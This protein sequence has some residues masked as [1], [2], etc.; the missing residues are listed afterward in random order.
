MKKLIIL[1]LI[2][3]LI[4][5]SLFSCK[6]TDGGTAKTETDTSA[7]TEAEVWAVGKEVSCTAHHRDY[8][9]IPY[10]LVLAVGPEKS[11]EWA[12]KVR[13]NETTVEVGSEGEYKC[14]CPEFNIKA[15]IDEFDI[16]KED[17]V[18][19]ADMVYLG[20]Y[21]TNVLYD[22]TPEE[23]AEYYIYSEELIDLTIKSQHFLFIEKYFQYE[24]SSEMYDLI[25]YD[26]EAGRGLSPS[27]PQTVQALGISKEGFESILEDCT[28]EN[29]RVYGRSF[30]FDYDI[31]LIFNEDGS[32][33]TLPTYEG[34]SALETIM[35][36]N[37]VFCGRDE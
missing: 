9:L 34:L 21:D 11:N 1:L 8:H 6:K 13:K 30:N 12:E 28:K 29:E 24:Y 7:E 22:K 35:K 5:T 10:N 25:V 14:G 32:Y 23:V 27:V 17:F 3:A 26:E 16:A 37:R 36:L 18:K 19:N 20:T 2:L 33:A 4:P 31:S 15:Y